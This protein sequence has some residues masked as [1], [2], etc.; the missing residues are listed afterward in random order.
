[1]GATVTVAG[2]QYRIH[3]LNLNPQSFSVVVEPLDAAART[4][5]LTGSGA[6]VEDDRGNRYTLSEMGTDY[7]PAVGRPQLA[8]QGMT[9]TPALAGGASQVRLTVRLGTLL[10]GP[11]ELD[12]DLK[13]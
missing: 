10:Y 1:M 5:P 4:R 2:G 9:F 3:S 8:R 12:L 7:S 11:W 13:P 6:T